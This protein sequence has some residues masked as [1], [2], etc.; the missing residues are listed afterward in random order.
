MEE[1]AFP[2]KYKVGDLVWYEMGDYGPTTLGIVV[3]VE[4][5]SINKLPIFYIH[6]PTGRVGAAFQSE[7]E[8]ANA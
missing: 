1:F 2:P 6:M 7:L 3:R 4:S 8:F 5:S